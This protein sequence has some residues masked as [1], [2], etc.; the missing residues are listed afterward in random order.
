MEDKIKDVGFISNNKIELDI[1]IKTKLR[2]YNIKPHMV[3]GIDGKSV[4]ILYYNPTTD[5]VFVKSF[6]VANFLSDIDDALY[7]LIKEKTDNGKIVFMQSL[8]KFFVWDDKEVINYYLSKQKHLSR[9]DKL[10][11]ILK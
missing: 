6:E 4:S 3:F 10:K 2:E 7:K 9:V 11:R 8:T 1:S 5:S